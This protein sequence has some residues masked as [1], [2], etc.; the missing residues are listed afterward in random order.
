MSEFFLEFFTTFD[1][2]KA[3]MIIVLFAVLTMSFFYAKKQSM[4]WFAYIE[5]I[6]LAFIFLLSFLITQKEIVKYALY[7]YSF[8]LVVFNAV[9]FS[10]ELRHDLFR[11]SWKKHSVA[12]IGEN[13]LTEDL[14][15]SVDAIAK[16]CQ[17]LSKGDVGAIIVVGDSVSESILD[18]GT[19][20]DSR[21]SAELIKALFY[22]KAPLH[23][24]AVV[25]NAN[26]IVAAGCYLP[27]TQALS[28][29]RDLGT[30]H[31][32]AIGV[33]EANPSLTVIV[34]S[35]ESG[36]ISAMHD[37]KVKRYLDVDSLK[38]ILLLAFGLLD[39]EEENSVWGE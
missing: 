33:S 4:T 30:R 29:P 27:L 31:R 19:R 9:L 5:C 6:V 26:R 37:G 28:L 15:N 16:A 14:K 13:V 7:T 22:P 23:D 36:I 1:F 25:I 10:P 18:S 38:M 39:A 35:E 12:E 17:D 2:G 34:V 3:I 24:G 32:A 11:I 20:V 8:A 21:V